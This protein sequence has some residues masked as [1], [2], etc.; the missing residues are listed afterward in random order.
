MGSIKRTGDFNQKSARKCLKC[1]AELKDLYDNT[2]N[3][4]AC[5]GQQHYVDIWSNTLT[6]TVVEKPQY[7][8]RINEYAQEKEQEKEAKI[9]AEITALTLQVEQARQQQKEV[10]KQHE[11]IKE[12]VERITEDKKDLKDQ[13]KNLNKLLKQNAEKLREAEENAKEWQDA[14][15]DLAKFLEELKAQGKW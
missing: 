8:R 5:C 14:A 15:E 11:Q 7:R 10:I 4:C 13:V 6:L 3:T 2:V 9:K 1:G 12:E